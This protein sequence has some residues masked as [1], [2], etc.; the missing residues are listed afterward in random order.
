MSAPSSRLAD[1][2]EIGELIGRG[3]MADVH[4]AHDTMLDRTVAVKLLRDVTEVDT[5]RFADEARLLSTLHHPHIVTFLDAGVDDERPWIALELADGATLAQLVAS[6]TPDVE[7]IRE[8]GSE[9]AAGLAHAHDRGV[10]HRDVKPSN[11]VLG[12]DGTAKLTDFGIAR[13]ADATAGLT[14][15]GH[16]VGTA[17]YLSPEQVRGEKVT[18]AGD[19]YA[20]GL[21]LLEVLSGTRAYPGTPVEA[22]VARLHR[23]P[24]IPASLPPGWPGLLTAMT[25]S[26][27]SLRPSAAAVAER[28]STPGAPAGWV[29]DQTST[30]EVV[31]AGRHRRAAAMIAVAAALAI[32]VALVMVRGLTGGS[33]ADAEVVGA[34]S[35]AT[36]PTTEASAS[37]TRTRRTHPRSQRQRSVVP[38]TVPTDAAT[39]ASPVVPSPTSS[40][41]SADLQAV[42]GAAFENGSD[43]DGQTPTRQDGQDGQGEE[44]AQAREAPREARAQGQGSGQRQR[45][46]HGQGQGPQEVGPTRGSMAG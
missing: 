9:V 5:R 18:G 21:V 44:A 15:T 14:L 36:R 1:R 4:R 6:S 45:Q 26:D 8:I 2:Y 34:P 35:A 13:L 22:A 41:S 24:L 17:A 19:V 43:E 10:V 37:T 39:P 32:V 29:A 7:R 33:P 12:A 40:A 46:R 38:V 30:A 16:T 28:L 27:P 3:G 20:L 25:A 11:I 31:L 42:E 23:S